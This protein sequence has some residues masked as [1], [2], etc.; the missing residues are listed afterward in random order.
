MDILCNF[1]ITEQ[2]IYL[3]FSFP[4]GRIFILAFGWNFNISEIFC[5]LSG[6]VGCDCLLRYYNLIS[7]LLLYLFTLLRLVL[8]ICWPL[9]YHALGLIQAHL[10]GELP[11]CIFRIHSGFLFIKLNSAWSLFSVML[12]DSDCDCNGLCQELIVNLPEM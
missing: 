12:P 3:I 10:F 9:G 11:T 1:F 6:W 7:P 4:V 5:C 8:P 2:S